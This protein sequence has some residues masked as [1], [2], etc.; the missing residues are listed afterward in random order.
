[1]KQSLSPDQIIAHIR[2]LKLLSECKTYV[3][4]HNWRNLFKDAELK[5]KT[6]I[7]LLLFFNGCQCKFCVLEQ[8]KHKMHESL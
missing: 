3:F 6:E 2:S 5:K 7:K 8:I 4:G 1:M